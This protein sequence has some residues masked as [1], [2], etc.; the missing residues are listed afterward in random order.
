MSAETARR[1][2]DTYTRLVD[3]ARLSC[4]PPPRPAYEAGAHGGTVSER[5]LHCIWFDQLV[6]PEALRTVAGEPVRVHAPGFWNLEAGPDFF[7]AEVQIGDAAARRG[8]VE[9]HLRPQDWMAHGHHADP[10]YNNTVLHVVL[11]NDGGAASVRTAADTTVPQLELGPALSAQLDELRAQLDIDDYPAAS[12]VNVGACCRHEL[13]GE[14]EGYWNLIRLAGEARLLLKAQRAAGAGDSADQRCYAMLLR[15]LGYKAF[16]DRCREL[17][18]RVPVAALWDTLEDGTDATTWFEALLLG[19]A[20]LIPED[21]AAADDA[22]RDRARR[23]RALWSAATQRLDVTPMTA[24]AW[25][26]PGVRPTNRPARRLA[27]AA[28]LVARA[29]RDGLA[30][31][32]RGPFTRPQLARH[33]WREL[34]GMLV[35]DADAFW[36]RRADPGAA[37]W[38]RAQRLV[39]PGRARILALDAAVPALLADA[40]ARDDG[41]LEARL[42][43][44]VATAPAQ[45]SNAKIRLALYRMNG[46]PDAWPR[47]VRTALHSQGLLHVVQEWC[48][49]RPTCEGCAVHRIL[50]DGHAR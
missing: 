25:R 6:R 20:G 37:P 17:A 24:D 10:R 8:D 21:A 12:V 18:R 34:E 16:A 15:A 45:A 49:E 29:G 4:E 5:L 39:G 31:W 40:R 22:G 47:R 19:A 26:A 41:P 48:L 44:A 3:A 38:P 23:L 1:F 32:L 11:R 30:A 36:G 14:A 33:A 28:R 2:S 13:T 42:Y 9:I 7:G 46:A 35:V 50:A 43:A 27:A